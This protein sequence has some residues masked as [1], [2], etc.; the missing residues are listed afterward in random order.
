MNCGQKK[1]IGEPLQICWEVGGLVSECPQF[2]LFAP[3]LQLSSCPSL[4][5]IFLWSTVLLGNDSLHSLLKNLHVNHMWSTGN[6][7]Q[8][9][10]IE[11]YVT[12]SAGPMKSEEE[13]WRKVWNKTFA[14]KDN[15][16]LMDNNNEHLM[17]QRF[18]Q[19]LISSMLFKHPFKG[20]C[21]EVVA[22]NI[23]V[24]WLEVVHTNEIHP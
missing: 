10:D 3:K 23:E 18:D 8:T 13:S 21:I 24:R 11:A 20:L 22:S 2:A 19:K 9:L 14:T 7:C 17:K 1:L 15:L 16:L 6:R 4:M 12:R 5:G